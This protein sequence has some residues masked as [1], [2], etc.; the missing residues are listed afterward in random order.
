MKIESNYLYFKYSILLIALSLL[1]GCDWFFKKNKDTSI[2]DKAKSNKI[3]LIDVNE[4]A[5]YNDAHIKDSLHIPYS[6]LDDLEN[7]SKPWNKNALVVVYCTNYQCLASKDVAK[8]LK[9]FGFNDVKVF[10]GGIAQWYQLNQKDKGY[11][12]EGSFKEEY[13]KNEL[14]AVEPQDKDISVITAAELKKHIDDARDTK[15]NAKI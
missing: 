4:D 5:I 6:K 8:K 12:I 3:I 7:I 2:E 11:E 15:S 13:L 10:T 14:E 9:E 1:S